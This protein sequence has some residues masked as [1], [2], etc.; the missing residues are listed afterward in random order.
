MQ[1]KQE[2]FWRNSNVFV[3]CSFCSPRHTD[4]LLH[5]SLWLLLSVEEVRKVYHAHL[6]ETSL[7][8]EGLDDSV[9]Q[10]L[11]EFAQCRLYDLL[12]DVA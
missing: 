7:I 6:L 12:V 9:I 2:Q 8:T 3:I 11:A 1:E 10:I 4:P 5:H